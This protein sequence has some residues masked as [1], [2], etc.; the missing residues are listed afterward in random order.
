MRT[1]KLTYNL[2]SLIEMIWSEHG[3]PIELLINGNNRTEDGQAWE[4]A[5]MAVTEAGFN[6]Q[7]DISTAF[8]LQYH[9]QAYLMQDMI[10]DA[11]TE[12]LVR[13]A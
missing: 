8:D 5:L 11:V 3:D 7:Q 2:K 12:K 6:I 10:S 9:R 4:H 1:V 13:G